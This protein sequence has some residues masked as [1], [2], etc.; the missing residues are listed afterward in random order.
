MSESDIEKQPRKREDI[1]AD[2]SWVFSIAA[3]VLANADI[4]GWAGARTWFGVALALLASAGMAYAVR[5]IV[6]RYGLSPRFARYA[7]LGLAL[8]SVLGALDATYRNGRHP[9]AP[10]P[11]EIN[12]DGASR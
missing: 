12:L 2:V 9:D 7:L 8:F 3:L 4:H 10:P 11:P 6:D 5:S 1:L